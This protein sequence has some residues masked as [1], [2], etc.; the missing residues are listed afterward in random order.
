MVQHAAQPANAAN[1]A[2]GRPPAAAPPPLAGRSARRRRPKARRPA[3][4]A[5][6]LLLLG[7]AFIALLWL[8][9]RDLEARHREAWQRDQDREARH[10]LLTREYAD[11]V[12]HFVA[13]ALAAARVALRRGRP[14]PLQPLPLQA[15]ELPSDFRLCQELVA[16]LARGVAFVPAQAQKLAA[17]GR[18]A[19]LAAVAQL[20]ELDY[21]DAGHRVAA[22]RLLALLARCAGLDALAVDAGGDFVS[23]AD[24]CRLQALAA[25][26]RQFAV[27]FA[28]DE[29][30]FAAVLRR[31]TLAAGSER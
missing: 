28:G 31:R 12:D 13:E 7:L 21:D 30:S 15:F 23:D 24:C 3:G 14:T 26:W 16:G 10:R 17:L 25:A 4:S 22:T 11:P 1:D 2:A 9:E 29:A 20:Q 5:R 18:P 8:Q 19:L 27:Q 6:S